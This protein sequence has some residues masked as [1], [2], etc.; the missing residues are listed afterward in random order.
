[1]DNVTPINRNTRRPEWLK[2]MIISKKDQQ[3]AS[4]LANALAVL[5]YHPDWVDVL[6]YDEFRDEVVKTGAPPF[7]E[8][9]PLGPWTDDD[10]VAAAAWLHRSAA[11]LNVSVSIVD[12]CVA[13]AAK[14][15]SFHPVRAYLQ[16]LKWDGE[17]RLPTWLATYLGVPPTDYAEQIGK[18]WLISAVARVMRPGCKVDCMLVLEGK[19]GKGKS[20][21]LRILGGDE[22]FSDT[23]FEIGNKDAYQALR[24]V[25][26]YEIAELD[27]IRG[28]EHSRVKAF[29]SSPV[30]SYRPSF[31]RRVRQF[32]RQC[33]FAGTT[34]ER[35]YLGDRTGNRRF[36]PVATHEI[37]LDALRR[38]RDQLWAE[39]F[40]RYE[41]GEVWHVD[42]KELSDL[43]AAEQ[44][45]R[46]LP[47]D[48][49]EIVSDWLENPTVPAHNDNGRVPIHVDEGVT[50]AQILL[51]AL[52]KK[53]GEIS[54]SDSIRAG[55]V[56]RAI[57][58]EPRLIRLKDQ[59]VTG[60]ERRYFKCS[61]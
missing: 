53:P 33:V 43:A 49:I 36:W 60:R 40:A 12:Q 1:M 20:T 25:W 58:W 4:C 15:H 5:Q 37:D 39:A 45:S 7:E 3:P 55:H 14:Q 57:S 61:K 18:R 44:A 42:T 29:V 23:P 48:W 46:E 56:L 22:W 59:N 24:N 8:A 50:T 10:S 28:R 13:L 35:Q 11:H 51:G 30:D 38:D 17:Q 9:S 2:R 34:N 47:D 54:H 32:P 27:A 41:S 16:G 26:L 21:A 31:G 19:T 52:R 6:A